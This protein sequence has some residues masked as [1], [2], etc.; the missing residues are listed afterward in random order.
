MLNNDLLFYLVTIKI[1]DFE[2]LVC[3]VND[4]NLC[5]TYDE[6]YTKL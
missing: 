3:N 4:K 5:C 6:I 1:G 2:K